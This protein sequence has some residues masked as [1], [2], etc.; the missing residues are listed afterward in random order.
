MSRFLVSG[1]ALV[2]ALAVASCAGA[3]ASTAPVTQSPV[4][5]AVA[6][7]ADRPDPVILISIDGFR[8]QGERLL[9][10]GRADL[11]LG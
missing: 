5:S 9:G 8:Q 11:G 3:P 6:T 7:Q 1:L 4:V 2:A 10:P